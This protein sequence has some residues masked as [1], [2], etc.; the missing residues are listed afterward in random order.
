MVQQFLCA[1]KVACDKSCLFIT[2]VI[3]VQFDK[4]KLSSICEDIFHL[5]IHC[6]FLAFGC[7]QV[8]SWMVPVFSSQ[9]VNFTDVHF[10]LTGIS[11]LII[12]KSAGIVRL[13][14]VTVIPLMLMLLNSHHTQSCQFA[15]MTG[16]YFQLV[17]ELCI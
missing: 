14:Q 4:S 7:L 9:I 5:I 16:V 1:F 17:N 13:L 6:L 8:I 2:C 10:N 3:L 12:T 11:T 15:L